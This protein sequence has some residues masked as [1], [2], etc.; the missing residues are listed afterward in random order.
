MNVVIVGGS[1]AGLAAA[2][3]CSARGLQVTVL[4][5]DPA[6]A[7][8]RRIDETLVRSP[9]RPTPQAAHSHA[10]LAKGH[11][12]LT[13]EAPEVI[14][15]LV[16]YGVEPVRLADRL[17]AS[18]TD[19]TARPGDDELTVLLARRSLYEAVLRSVAAARP[20]VT[21]RD[22]IEMTDLLWADEPGNGAPP[23]V[24]G[25]RTADGPLPADVVLDATGRR[26]RMPARLADHGVT[27]PETVSDCGIAYYTRFYRLYLGERIGPLNRGYTAGS[28]FD[29]YS[30]LVFP[31]DNDTFSV[32]FGIL[33]EDR[34]LRRL[35]HDQAFAAAAGA[36]PLV[37]GCT[38]RAEPISGVRSM[39]AMKNRLRRLVAE[40]GPD[41][42]GPTRP[43]VTGLIPLA[44]AAAISNPAHSRGCSLALAHCRHVADLLTAGLD[45]H[46]LALAAD[47]SITEELAPW[48]EDSVRQDEAR[49]SRWRPDGGHR[50]PDQPA[51][52]VSN[53]EAWTAAHHDREVWSAFTRLQQLLATIPDVLEDPDI[54]ARVRATQSRGLGL[55]RIL[56]PDHGSMA[57]L[58]AEHEPSTA[59]RPVRVPS[60]S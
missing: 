36:I 35:R 29:R 3:F 37:D 54:V 51:G 30:C 16:S 56:G 49:L 53:G 42:S 13:R 23:R 18:L 15:A 58:L 41:G 21:I 20:E 43:V 17:P 1:I 32:T 59:G 46:D 10:F 60:P 27:L 9:R 5:A 24:V 4:E 14:D 25:V 45:A 31:A 40:D 34:A 33:P 38:S 57:Q 19:R 12:L 48:V 26:S 47:R 7:T 52:S 39:T 50:A 28:S 44:D 2:L 22:G 8:D 6:A 55:P 11:R